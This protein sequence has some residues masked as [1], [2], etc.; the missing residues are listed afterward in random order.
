MR[1]SEIAA[2]QITA[3]GTVVLAVGAI[4][5]AIFAFLAFRKQSVEVETLLEERR[6]EVAE[7]RREQA[8]HVLLW[9]EHTTICHPPKEEP[10]HFLVGHIE[11]ASNYPIYDVTVY[12]YFY[13]GNKLAGPAYVIGHFMPE[14]KASTEYEDL[15]KRGIRLMLEFRDRS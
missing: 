14:T 11:N 9:E 5:S 6:T 13:D 10:V 8:V 1:V 2:V 7:R 4:L 15:D 3:V 12:G